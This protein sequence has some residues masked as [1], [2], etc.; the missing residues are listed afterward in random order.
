MLRF[1]FRGGLPLLLIAGCLPMQILDPDGETSG[2]TLV[3]TSP[4]GAPPTPAPTTTKV[5]YAPA[6]KEIALRVDRIGREILAANPQ[7]GCRPLFA[8]IGAPQSEIFHQGQSFVH[9]TEGLAKQCQSDG[10]LAALLCLELA[11]MVAEREAL[12]SPQMRRPERRPPMD[13]PIGNAGQFSTPDLTRMAELAP[14]DQE[15]RQR[16][17]KN[18]PAPDAN[19]LARGYLEKAG[20]AKS[21]LEAVA[22]LVSAAERNCALE[23]QVNGGTPVPAWTPKN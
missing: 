21:E 10:Q 5:S 23:R 11:K 19:V 2:T 17:T 20:Y 9:L 14:Y 7:I 18:L 1:V 8:T 4:F 3:S 6:S 13:V 16:A 12:A 15:R 22:S